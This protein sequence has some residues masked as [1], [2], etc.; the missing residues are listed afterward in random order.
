MNTLVLE[1]TLLSD[2]SANPYTVTLAVSLPSYSDVPIATF[3]FNINIDECQVTNF[4]QNSAQPNMEQFI[5]DVAVTFDVPGFIQTPNC[6]LNP[7]FSA[8]IT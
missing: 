5:Y 1:S 8:V 6:G 2:Y 4:V 3:T 7:T